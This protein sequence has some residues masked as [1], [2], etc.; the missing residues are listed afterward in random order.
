[1]LKHVTTNIF[2]LRLHKYV[3]FGKK[4]IRYFQTL[5]L[6]WDIRLLWEYSLGEEWG[7]IPHGDALVFV[8]N[9]DTQRDGGPILTYKTSKL[10]KVRHLQPRR[11][12]VLA[13]V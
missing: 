7:F 2:S 4:Y 6:L 5:I 10:Y 3:L 12:T 1:M 8:D 13:H 9:H 11:K